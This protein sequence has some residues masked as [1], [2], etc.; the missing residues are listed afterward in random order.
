MA[1]GVEKKAETIMAT[2]NSPATVEKA[3]IMLRAGALVSFPT[4]TVY[5]LGADATNGQ[6]VARIFEAKKRPSFNPLIVHVA[7][8]DAARR[9]AVFDSRADIVAATLWPGPLTLILPIAPGAGLSDLVTAGLHT[10]AVRVPDH[11]LAQA[12]L[13]AA[14]IP[15]AAPS[16]NPSGRVSPTTPM[17]VASGLGDAVDLIVAGGRTQVGIESTILDLS[18][19]KARLLRPGAVLPGEIESLIGPIETA[20]SD[21]ANAD[22]PIAPGQLRSHYAP[23]APVRLNARAVHDGEIL[24]TF[25]PDLRQGPN[26]INLSES[27]DLIE[28]AASL[29]AALLAADRPGIAGIAVAPIPDDGIGVAI[30]DRLRRAAAPRP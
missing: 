2:G 21:D 20:S 15:V 1:T 5:G 24:I 6:A 13:R 9:I 10:V 16:A 12:I 3:G 4:E 19:P 8:E 25:G 30:N 7:D 14:A 22:R 17:H 29:F 28:A 27:G 11:D 26:V 23:N 18:G